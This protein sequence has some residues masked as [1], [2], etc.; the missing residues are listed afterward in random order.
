LADDAV[1]QDRSATVFL[2]L[3]AFGQFNSPQ[4][5]IV[6]FGRLTTIQFVIGSYLEP[7]VAGSSLIEPLNFVI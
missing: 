1:D 7:R 4:I 6:V 3:F 5:P 2:K